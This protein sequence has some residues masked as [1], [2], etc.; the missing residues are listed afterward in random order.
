MQSGP[1]RLALVITGLEPGGAERALTQLALR[2]NRELF[3]PLVISLQP[4]P[5]AAKCLMVDQLEAAEVP[6]E[7]LNAQ[8]KWQIGSAVW[9]LSRRFQ[10]LQP[11]IVQSFLF[12]ANVVAALAGRLSGVPVVAGIR[13][14]DP[15]PARHRLERWIEPL[16]K[17]VVCVSHSVA[18]FSAQTAGLPRGKLSVIPNGVDVAKFRDALPADRHELGLPAQQRFFI[19]I[20]RLDR[21]KGHDWLLPQMPAI[22]AQRPQHS[23]LIV[24]D[25]PE[26]KRLQA[27]TAEL[28]LQQRVHFL[29][30]RADVP[31]LLKLA[32][33]LLLPSRWEGMPNVLLEAMA[34]GLP[35]V[36]T[37][38]EGA[39]EIAGLLQGDQVVN[40]GD[41]QAFTERVLAV[42]ASSDYRM[43]LGKANQQRAEEHFSLALMAKAYEDIYCQIINS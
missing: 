30:W 32:E 16:V 13:V 28:G 27:Q 36:S 22:F 4:R 2:I 9:R 20:G 33:V 41:A 25:G 24:G 37:A 34:A 26:R 21:Q 7:I 17:K 5:T 15:S 19:A 6:V 23:L 42:T 12:H 18:H 1:R 39:D 14:A 11:A 38:V 8:S 31:Q 10:S 3:Q 40:Q 35:F 29:G 43:Q